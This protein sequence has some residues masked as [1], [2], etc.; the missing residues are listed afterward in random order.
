MDIGQA[1][2]PKESGGVPTKKTSSP[3][4]TDNRGIRKQVRSTEGYDAQAALLRPPPPGEAGPTVKDL[5]AGVLILSSDP[6]YTDKKYLSWFRDQVKAK[7]ACWGGAFDPASVYL[8]QKSVGPDKQRVIA[9]NWTASWGTVPSTKEMPPDFSWSPIDARAAV[10]GVHALPGWAEVR[11]ENQGI[12]DNMLGGELN[13]VSRAARDELRPKFPGLPSKPP[14]DQAATLEGLIGSQDALPALSTEEVSTSSVTFT[15]SAPVAVKDYEFR[16]K[17]AD[18][19]KYT[20]SFSDGT[21][22]EIVAPKAPEAGL[23]SHSVAEA[24]DALANLPA[25]NRARVQRVVLNV[26]TNPDDPTW[27]AKYHRPG[28]HSYMT[29]GASGEVTIY[30]DAVSNP[31][32][33][34]NVRRGSMIHE[35]GHVWSYQEWG[36]DTTKGKWAE[37]KKCMDSDKVS[38]SR[39]AT[40]DIAEDVAETVR[41][42]GSTK[43]RPQYNEYKALVPKRWAM[44]EKELQ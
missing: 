37:W 30:P 33:D 14:K 20:A 2:V 16:G 19:E 8:A 36:T 31:L 21:R 23:H 27:A 7:V 29:A 28:F 42:Y 40:A 3:A 25:R 9:M 18:A 38:V 41:A 26:V 10:A 43:G 12:L 6:Q 39:Y 35:T 11:A 5:P 4:R 34:A 24:A 1:K 44:L 15:L 17:K 22:I 13:L 32:P